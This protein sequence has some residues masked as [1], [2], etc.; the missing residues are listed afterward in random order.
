L[1]FHWSTS[2][3]GGQVI[4]ANTYTYC[5]NKGMVSIEAEGGRD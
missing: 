3:P 1:S 2:T 5:P 4:D